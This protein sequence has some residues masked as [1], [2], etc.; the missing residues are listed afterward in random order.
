MPDRQT[1]VANDLPTAGELLL[2]V[3]G[4]GSKT[5]CCL[6]RLE[7]NGELSVLG[8]GLAGASNPRVIGTENAAREIAASIEQARSAAHLAALDVD[9]ALLAIAGTLDST[10]RT[11]LTECLMGLGLAKHLTVIPD[12]FLLIPPS[13][14]EAVGLIA[15][16]GSVGIARDREGRIAIAGGWGPLMGDEGS[17]FAIGRAALRQALAQLEGSCTLQS[18]SVAVCDHLKCT[19]ATALKGRIAQAEDPRQFVAQ[20][21]PVVLEKANEGDATA[22]EIVQQAASALSELVVRLRD[23]LGLSADR[24][25]LSLS[26]GLFQAGDLLQSHLMAA[27]KRE[28][29]VCQPHPIT[30]PTAVCLELLKQGKLPDPSRIVL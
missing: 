23:R 6:A 1:I 25:H 16:T 2:A 20:L 7:S 26:G 22:N 12:L 9:Q 4:G 10:H 27:L 29:I 21:A 5:A 19:T 11:R 28:D 18:L 30:D 24:L 3:D 17:G 13:A 8:R 15:G 14:D